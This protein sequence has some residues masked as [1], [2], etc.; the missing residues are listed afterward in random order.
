[1]L[2]CLLLLAAAHSYAQAQ[3]CRVHVMWDVAFGTYDP[4]QS[5]NL[6]ATGMLR[7]KCSPVANNVSVR[8]DAGLS[9]SYQPR[10]MQSGPARLGY[11]L[12]L[13]AS[14]TTIWGDG[15]SGTDYLFLNQLRRWRWIAI[16]GRSPLGQDVAPGSY[17]DTV[18]VTIDW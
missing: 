12:Y 18:V 13:D 15:T 14:R 5:G 1:M 16:Y 2:L 11:N 6:D 8:L 10:Y 9:G 3:N 17:A 4:L 7:M